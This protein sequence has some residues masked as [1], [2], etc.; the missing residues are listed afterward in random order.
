MPSARKRIKLKARNKRGGASIAEFGPALGLILI[1]IFFPLVDMLAMGVS[2]GLCM[3]LNYNQVH[4]AALIPS[5]EA[6]NNAGPIKKG[7][8]DQW[9]NGMGHFVNMS[10]YPSTNISYRNGIADASNNQDKIVTVSTTVVCNPF[11]P[12]PLP[13]VN[14]PG[15]NG[16]MT[17]TLTSECQ[18]ENPDNVQ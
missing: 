9:L 2:Y 13:V 7:I 16:S 8:P 10:G 1:C 18:M 15:L 17:F 3:V 4:E 6:L 5:S 14:V 12:I 11:L